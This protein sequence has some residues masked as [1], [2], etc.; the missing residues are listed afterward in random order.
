[1]QKLQNKSKSVVRAFAVCFAEKLAGTPRR[2]VR[3]FVGR[4][5]LAERALPAEIRISTFASRHARN[6]PSSIP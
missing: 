1:M 2:A 5:A 6:C 4:G 3:E